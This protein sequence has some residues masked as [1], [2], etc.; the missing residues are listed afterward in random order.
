[1]PGGTNTVL[2][3][4]FN[5]EVARTP[6]REARWPGGNQ[7]QMGNPQAQGSP[8]EPPEALAEN[9]FWRDFLDERDEILKLKWIDSKKEGRDIGFQEAIRRWL[10]HRPGWRKAHSAAAV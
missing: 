4:E 7:L 6:E 10:K 8:P 5:S 2:P 3:R 1:M 9:Q